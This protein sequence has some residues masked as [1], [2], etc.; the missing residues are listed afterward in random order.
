[1]L[2]SVHTS[3][4]PWSIHMMPLLVES[5]YLEIHKPW[6]KSFHVSKN[7]VLGNYKHR[8][9]IY[10]FHLHNFP[11]YLN[12]REAYNREEGL[13]SNRILPHSPF[14][15]FTY[16]SIGGWLLSNVVSLSA[17]Q[18]CQ[19]AICM[20]ISPPLSLLPTLP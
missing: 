3:H 20:H 15:K 13:R 17:V 8:S 10:F 11:L 14:F 9:Y 6:S 2:A 12:G 19:S 7:E 5:L 18:Q 4:A 1:M 16:F